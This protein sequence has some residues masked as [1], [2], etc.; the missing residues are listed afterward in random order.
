MTSI[1]VSN[2]PIWLLLITVIIFT[3]SPVSIS[4]CA[5]MMYHNGVTYLAVDSDEVVPCRPP[6]YAPPLIRGALSD[7]FVWRLSVWRLSR[8][9]GLN[10]EQRPRKTKIGTEVAHVTRDSVTTFRVKKSKVKVARPLWLAVQVK[11]YIDSLYATAQSQP[12][13]VDHDYSWRKALWAPQ[14]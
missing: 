10:R 3:G 11:T 9:S 5:V 14:A 7:A 13:P 1:R 2:N 6:C 12:L 8:T 4:W